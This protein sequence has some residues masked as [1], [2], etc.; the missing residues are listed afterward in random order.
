MRVKTMYNRTEMVENFEVEYFVTKNDVFGVGIRETAPGGIII[1][2]S[3]SDIFPTQT[4][5]EEFAEI[6]ANHT[7]LPVSLRDILKDYFIEKLL[8]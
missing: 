3:V 4:T 7:V 2:D 8:A 6:L 1:E 5:A